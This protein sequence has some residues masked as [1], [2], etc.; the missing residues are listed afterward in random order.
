MAVIKTTPLEWQPNNQPGDFAGTT[1]YREAYCWPP[2]SDREAAA[3]SVEGVHAQVV[4][5]SSMRIGFLWLKKVAAS[6]VALTRFEPEVDWGRYNHPN[7]GDMRE[8]F[9]HVIDRLDGM[10][11]PGAAAG[12]LA[13]GDLG[14]RRPHYPYPY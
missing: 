8:R 9:D 11:R 7:L 5:E 12:A 4:G 14:M 1:Y 13:T 6:K 2:V 10:S 3:A